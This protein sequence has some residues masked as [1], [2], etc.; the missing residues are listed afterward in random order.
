MPNNRN[1]FGMG[2]PMSNPVKKYAYFVNKSAEL[3][4][5]SATGDVSY[6]GQNRLTAPS[7]GSVC[8]I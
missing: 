4:K 2:Q 7:S 1:T 5:M 8:E 3:V 6:S